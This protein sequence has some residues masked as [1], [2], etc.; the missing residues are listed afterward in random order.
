[1]RSFPF[2]LRYM[3]VTILLPKMDRGILPIDD[4]LNKKRAEGGFLM[5][6]GYRLCQERCD[7]KNGQLPTLLLLAL[8]GDRIGSEQLVEDRIIDALR[9]RPGQHCMRARRKDLA[10]TVRLKR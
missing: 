2:L 3:L 5:D 1:M 6:P 7:R 4:S 10:R 9:S 8:Q